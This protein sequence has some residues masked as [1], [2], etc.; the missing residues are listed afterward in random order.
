MTPNLLRRRRV[1]TVIAAAA[2][3]PLLA[4]PLRRARE[5][6]RLRVWTGSALGA[7]AMLQIHHPD[8]VEADRLIARSLAEIAR[9]EAIFSLYRP[10]SALSLLNRN[11]CLDAPPFDLV[12]LLAE[13]ER[14]SRLT[15]GAF[16]A[17]VQPL[18]DVY[19]RHFSRPDADE[20]GPP[21]GAVEAALAHVGHGRVQV[22]PD[23][24]AFASPGTAVTL[25]GIAQG[26]ITD[27]VVDL[28]R[29][30]GVTNSL[31]SID[32]I[33]AIGRMPSG[34]AWPVGL[35]DPRA[36]GRVVD[37]VALIDRAVGTSGGY[38]TQFDPAGRFNHIF[39]PADGATS[40]RYLAVSVVAPDAMSADALSTAFS[41]MPLEQTEPVVAALGLRAY[42]TRADGSRV[43][44]GLA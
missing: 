14:F 31:V 38:G 20:S 24:L 18:W 22:D 17:T 32:E 16:D 44:H 42:L 36:P 5:T 39:S 28:L 41:L 43:I 1:I 21:R 26:Y 13:A 15:N 33:R 10:D 3:L 6:S 30:E 37:H 29:A 2:G 27:R 9:L 11:G 25:N 7:S 19:A 4:L 34:A 35:E 12:R 40:W 8:P 23:R